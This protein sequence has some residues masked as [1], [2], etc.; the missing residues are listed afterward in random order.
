MLT[1]GEPLLY[2]ATATFDLGDD[3]ADLLPG[4]AKGKDVITLHVIIMSNRNSSKWLHIIIP[5]VLYQ[6]SKRV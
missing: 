6:I 4:G 2:L 3:E 1:Q 5:T